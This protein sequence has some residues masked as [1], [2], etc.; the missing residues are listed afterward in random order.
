MAGDQGS[1]SDDE[2]LHDDNFDPEAAE[3]ARSLVDAWTRSDGEEAFRDA[4]AASALGLT[5]HVDTDADLTGALRWHAAVV[6][7][8][9]RLAY[10]RDPD[11]VDR[12]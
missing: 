2:H 5:R 7:G 11:E 12:P 3:T 8:V 1:S 4:L 6:S 10:G 9:L